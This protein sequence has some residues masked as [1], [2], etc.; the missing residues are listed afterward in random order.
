M[1]ERSPTAGWSSRRRSARRRRRSRPSSASGSRPSTPGWHGIL[2]ATTPLWS[3]LIGVAIGT[4]R[5]IGP[6]RLGG[7]LL[8]FAGTVL[9][10][11]PWHV[12]GLVGWSTLA[13]LGA[14]A[15]YAVAF[16]YMARNLTGRGSA[17]IALSAAQLLVA[18]GL[19]ALVLPA[20]GEASVPLHPQALVAVAVLGIFS[21]GVTFYLSYRLIADEGATSTATVGYRLPVVSVALGAI[22]LDERLVVRVV[23]GML[24]VLVGVALTRRNRPSTPSISEDRSRQAVSR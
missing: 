16:A 19:S 20:G 18:A 5:G 9:I 6:T 12:A 22:V 4:E 24:V 21:T 7:L 8:G 10:F 15:S 2:N 23:A 14:A 11:G 17:P 3:L 13:P 1:G